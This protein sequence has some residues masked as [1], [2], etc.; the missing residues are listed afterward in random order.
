M[1]KLISNIGTV[2]YDIA[3]Y[4]KKLLT[5]LTKQESVQKYRRPYKE[6]QRNKNSWWI[7]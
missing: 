4:L 6:A 2:T 1:V 3:K 5:P 7:Y